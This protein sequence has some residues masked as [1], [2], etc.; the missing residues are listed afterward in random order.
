M[1]PG[2]YIPSNESI[3]ANVGKS[4]TAVSVRNTGDRPIQVGSHTHFFEVNKALEFQRKQSYGC[5]LNI[6]AGTS[7]RF[8]PGDTKEIELTEFGGKKIV[9]GFSGLVNGNLDEKKEEAFK[10][11]I[12]KGFK[13]MT[14]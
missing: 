5:H 13:G 9:Y 4:T 12:E 8:E 3:I 14:Q 1:I 10:K 11:A 7:V 6:P 2:E